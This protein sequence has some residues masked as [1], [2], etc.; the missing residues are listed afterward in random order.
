MGE[1]SAAMA[2]TPAE[3]VDDEIERWLGR[4]CLTLDLDRSGIYERDAPGWLVRT[5][6]T[7]V[8]PNIPPFPKKYDPQKLLQKT[9]RLV[10]SGQRIVF[11][12]PDQIPFDLGDAKRFVSR[13]GPKASAVFP[14]WAG[15]RVIGGASFGRFR[16]PRDWS[17]QLLEHLA[18]VVRIFGAAIERKQ[19]EEAARL[20]REELALAQRRSMMGELVASLTHELNQPLGAVLSNLGGLARLVSQG[21]PDP[22]LAS[23]AVN[24][25]IEDAKRAGEIVRRVRAMFKGNGTKKAPIDIAAL[26]SEVVGLL[27]SEAALRKIKIEIQAPRSP[28]TVFGD[29]ILLQ[30]CV[31]N[32]LMNAFDALAEVPNDRRKVTIDIV[33][34]KLEW[35]AVSVRDAG[36]GIHPSVGG[37][38]FEPFVTT[39]TNGMGLGLLVTRSIV[40]DHGG[41]VSVKPNPERGTTFTFTLPVADRKR[42]AG[43]PRP[44]KKTSQKTA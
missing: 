30:Q 32:L 28:L 10:L 44:S 16:S 38:L 18:L 25:A 13:Y 39:K 21:N 5:S 26:V 15:G 27:A 11:S 6:H 2:Q 23:R 43:S 12:H 17:P 22:A 24:N 41:K 9:T 31:L 36:Q 34:E 33:R 7:W 42:P 35:I 8:R 1:L 20:V 29:R 19:A 4:I 14:I 40:E 3:A 37:R